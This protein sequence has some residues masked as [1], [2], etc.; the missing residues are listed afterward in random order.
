MRGSIQNRQRDNRTLCRSSDNGAMNIFG[1][2]GATDRRQ[3]TRQGGGVVL[4]LLRAVLCVTV[5]LIA[6]PPSLAQPAGVGLPGVGASSATSVPVGRVIVRYRATSVAQMAR[7]SATNAAAVPRTVQRA[8]ALGARVG[9]PLTD[10]RALDAR[11]QVIQASG[12]DSATLAARLRQ[13]AEVELAVVDGRR[14]IQAAPNDPLYADGQTATTPQA[15]QWYLRAPNPMTLSSID[16]ESAWAISSGNPNLVV[17]VLDT[18][19][20]FDHP[21]LTSKLLP[22]YDFV[23]ADGTVPPLTYLGAN[24]GNGWDAD[25]SDPGDWLSA[26]DLTNPV[27]VGC[28]GGGGPINSSWHGTQVSGLIAAASN[29]G[30]GMAGIADVKILPVR[31]L[32]KCGGFDSDI[33]A[34]MRWAA[35]LSV[36]GVPIN[37][38]PARLINMSLGSAGSCSDPNGTGSLYQS[39]VAELRLAG[40]SVIASAGNDSRAVN[41]PANCPGVI[42]V[43][44]LRQIGT[45]NGF[46]S[47]GPDVV[48]SAPGGNCVNAASQ[49]C[50]YPILS[51]TDLGTS[52]PL[53][54]GYTDGGA[55]AAIGTSFSAPQVTGVAALMLSIN[56]SLWPDELRT[57]LRSSARAFPTTS[58]DPTVTTCVDPASLPAAT[59][60]LECFCTTTTCGAGMLDAGA[61]VRAAQNTLGQMLVRLGVVGQPALGGVVT[62]DGSGSMP[63]PG[64]TL[65]AWHWT[66]DAPQVAEFVGGD[67]RSSIGLHLIRPGSVTLTLTVTDSAG[68][69]LSATQTLVVPGLKADGVLDRAAGLALD[70]IDALWLVGAMI[71][72]G[73]GRRRSYRKTLESKE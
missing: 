29:N 55:T 71:G 30:V 23:G 37:P 4:P 73:W 61:A 60:Q 19:V 34:A 33:L 45:K 12:L 5:A 22:G 2:F 18:G 14:R 66:L 11:T 41:L 38:N 39:A 65:S 64:T 9:L 10:G 70:G 27:F 47:L 8:V 6:Q 57:L 13:D 68:A 21:E 62:L 32:G 7:Q 40:V 48:I 72:V 56:A 26:A 49:P 25:A 20:R 52:S 3:K 58:T 43:G 69:S 15:G 46:S 54:P 16:V 24:D 28:D 36:P 1:T 44:G 59:D 17:A 42:A 35:G 63:V 67:G 31:V 53:G 51:A 50:L